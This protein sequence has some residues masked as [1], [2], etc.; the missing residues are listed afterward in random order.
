MPAPL[1]VD[2]EAVKAHALSY[3]LAEAARAYGLPYETVRQWSSRGQWLSQAGVTSVSQPL[4]QSMQPT[5]TPVTVTPA[6]A[7]QSSMQRLGERSKVRLARGLAR[8]AL[9]VAHMK[10][11][12]VVANAQQIKALADTGA[13]LHGWGAETSGGAMLGISLSV[14]VSPEQPVIDVAATVEPIDQVD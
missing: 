8:G 7:V 2:R 4:P 9:H 5:V 14:S 13:K 10:P 1:A 6:Q 11:S 12:T 3:G